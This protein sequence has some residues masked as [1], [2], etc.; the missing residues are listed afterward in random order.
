M[1]DPIEINASIESGFKW[2]FQA[3]TLV[4]YEAFSKRIEILRFRLKSKPL[5]LDW[6]ALLLVYR[7]AR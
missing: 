5:L 1:H 2:F 3:F 7:E 6:L 4:T